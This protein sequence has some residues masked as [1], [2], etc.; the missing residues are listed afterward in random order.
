MRGVAVAV[1]RT[2][3]SHQDVVVIIT[4]VFAV[5][6]DGFHN[7]HLGYYG[8]TGHFGLDGGF[9]F[10]VRFGLEVT[11]DDLVGFGVTV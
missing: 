4:A 3:A 5:S 6:G 9:T 10:E 2:G 11:T 7:F 1:A 8:H